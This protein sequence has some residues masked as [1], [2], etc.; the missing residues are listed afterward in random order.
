MTNTSAVPL[1]INCYLQNGE[2]SPKCLHQLLY[3][4]DDVV[5]D[6]VCES[7][8][9]G[10]AAAGAVVDNGES[11]VRAGRRTFGEG[12]EHEAFGTSRLLAAF[13]A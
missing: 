8:N 2:A 10:D 4:A 1:L 5:L 7:G 12:R 3:T 6:D 13:K 9:C 11:G